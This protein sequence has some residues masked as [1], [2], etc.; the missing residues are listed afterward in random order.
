MKTY[1]FET[2]PPPIPESEIVEIV[3]TDIVVAGAGPAG[4]AAAASAAEKGARVVLIEKFHRIAAPGGPGAPFVGSKLQKEREAGQESGGMPAPPAGFMPPAGMPMAPPPGMP[5][6]GPDAA[7]GMP[8]M[9]AMHSESGPTPTKEELVEG[10]LEASAFRADERLIKLWADNSGE[11]ADWLIEMADEQDLAVTCGRFSH[12]FSKPGCSPLH[13]SR[14]PIGC[15][16]NEG[17]LCLLNMMASHGAKNGLDIRTATTAVRLVRPGNR[18]RVLGLI[19]QKEDGTYVQF[20]AA[21]AVILC[22]GDYGMDDEMLEK[23]CSWALGLP[24]LMQETVTGDGHKMGLWAGAPIE[25][26][27]HCAMLHFNSTNEKPVIHYRPVGMM[28]RAKFLYVN[29]RGERIVN[30]GQSDEFLANI[31]LRQPGKVFWQVFDSR[32]VTDQNREDVEKALASGAVLKA[33]TIE[34]LAPHFGADPQVFKAAVDRYNELVKIGEDLDFGKK[35]EH[36]TIPVDQA[37]YYVC[38]SPPNLLCAMGGFKRNGEGQVLDADL[39][40]IPGLYA[41]GNNTGSFWGDTY[42]MGFLG[43]ISRSH[44]VVFGRLAG[45]HAAGQ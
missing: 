33:D 39:N 12:L 37:P 1:S 15:E 42:P 9:A 22:T 26:A 4:L 23:Y 44:A 7:G 11:A 29:K 40:V 21:K 45:I 24:K 36:M 13:L 6:M 5:G 20:N 14:T 19:A 41:A 43:G 2:P 25:D 38:E 8:P 17:E 27:P 10:L 30:E 28:N 18:G 31:V 34:G 35:A 16:E 3:E 32:W